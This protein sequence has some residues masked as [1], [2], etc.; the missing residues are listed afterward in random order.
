ML[1]FK[2]SVDRADAVARELI[3]LGV[4]KRELVVDA[5]SDAQPVYFEFMPTGEAGNRRAEIYL[6]S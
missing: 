2:V 3:R 6:E 1:N 4:K 5:M